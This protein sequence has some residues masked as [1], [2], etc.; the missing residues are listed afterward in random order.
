MPKPST[1][2]AANPGFDNKLWAATDFLRG[3]TDA[4]AASCQQGCW[5][6]RVARMTLQSSC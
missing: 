4:Y 6:S 5:R 3:H 2:N 1:G